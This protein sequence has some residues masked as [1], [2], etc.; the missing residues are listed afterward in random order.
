MA[1]TKRV[2]K[3]ALAALI[4]MWAAS[5]VQAQT[6]NVLY[7]FGSHAGDPILPSGNV[8]QGDDGSLYATS[9]LGGAHAMGAVFKI[10]PEGRMRVL[11]SFCAQPNCT[12]GDAPNGGLVLRPDG[13]FIGV[14]QGGGKYGFGTIFDITQTGQMTVLYDFTGGKDGSYPPAPPVLGP[15][16]TFYG[17]AWEG[18]G[19]SGCGTV[20]RI[21]NSGAVYGGFHLLHD[22]SGPDGC[23][24]TAELTPGADGNLY[25]PVSDGGTGTYGVTF[26]ITPAGALTVLHDFVGVPDGYDPVASMILASDG[27]FYGTTRGVGPP[28]SGGIFQMTPAGT[29]TVLHSMSGNDGTWLIGGVIEGSDG[30]FYGA[31][32]QGGTGTCGNGGAGCGTIFQVT[33]AGSLTVLHNFDGTAGYWVDATPVQHTNGLLFGD[34]YWGGIDTSFCT[35]GCGVFYSL[36][37]SLPAFVS[38][39]PS[40]GSVGSMVRILGQGFTA[41]TTVRFNGVQASAT[42]V[43]GTNLRAVVPSGATNGFVTVTASGGTLKSNQQFRVTP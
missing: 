38:V 9:N 2:G 21:T 11:Y 10:T 30:N 8:V 41:A 7:T 35:F 24:P 3:F 40:S 16:G 5:G 28:F 4:G 25:G 14:A 6:Y 13:H 17:T 42:V 20:Y 19:T 39:L 1:K 32:E 22:F 26:K 34:T 36:D 29:V 23:N 33:P 18:G 15:N 12:D 31:A 37:E 27:N 43:S